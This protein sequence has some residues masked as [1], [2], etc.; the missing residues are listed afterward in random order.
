MADDR[1]RN[2]KDS[3]SHNGALPLKN[4]FWMLSLA[5]KEDKMVPLTS[6]AIILVALA[7]QL[8][9][10]LIGPQII[11]QVETGQSF[12][13][14]LAT[15]VS[16]SSALFLLQALKS[17]LQNNSLFRRIALRTSVVIMVNRKTNETSYPNTLDPDFL[18]LRGKA[19]K[20]VS[21]NSEAVEHMWTTLTQLLISFFGFLIYLFFLTDINNFLIIIISVTTVTS[22]FVSRHMEAWRYKNRDREADL[23]KKIEY[24]EKLADSM[25]PA[26]DIRLFNL[27]P[28]LEGV[29]DSLVKALEAF[30]NKS[31][32]KILFAN[33]IDVFLSLLGNGLAYYYLIRLTLSQ[34]LPASSFLLYFTAVGG[35]S[36]MIKG[37]LKELETLIKENW[38]I[39]P[40]R[41]FLDF[42]EPFRFSGGRELPD[43]KSPYEIRL[44][45]VSYKYPGSE[46]YVLKDL[47]LTISPGE[48]VAIVGL[49]G[50][51]KT[52]LIKLASGLLDPTDG[53]VLIN[54]VDIREF[55]RGDYYSVFSTVSQNFSV[56]DTT[57]AENV[58]QTV[59]PFDRAKVE[60]CLD[61]AGLSQRIGQLS[62]G[63]DTK[64][65]KKLWDD[66]LELSGGEIQRLMLARALYRNAPILVLDEPTAALDPLEENDIYLKYNEMTENKT[67]IFVSHRLASTRFCDRILFIGE[68]GIQEEGSHEDLLALGGAYSD[69][70]QVQS[71]YYRDGQAF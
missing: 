15:I 21:A 3:V 57:I 50:A 2:T 49:N 7:L 70:F 67:S 60:Q 11:K 48:K 46:N 47:D 55:N 16:L 6:L 68:G 56:L 51:G 69:L 35:L 66:G 27:S 62:S 19:N 12:R 64:L 18:K 13:L 4:I 9:Q 54:G 23:D 8:V 24:F 25:A 61:L 17:Y 41:D 58:S 36:L 38:E 31:E 28:W 26:K 10:L 43:A 45:K 39:Q 59:K 14:L 33:I 65:G 22:F 32:R 42:P 37:L 34:N 20:S 40:V 53:R 71:R 1:N 29:Y 63:I 52:T 44:E 30:I 5:M